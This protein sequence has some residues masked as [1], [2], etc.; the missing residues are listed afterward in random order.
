MAR[1]PVVLPREKPDDRIRT[2]R[3]HRGKEPDGVLAQIEVATYEIL[4]KHE[5]KTA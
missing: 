4:R 3:E 5:K 1:I 2:E